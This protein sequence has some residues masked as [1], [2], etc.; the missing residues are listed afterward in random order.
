MTNAVSWVGA[1]FTVVFT[2]GWAY[3]VFADRRSETHV[4][5]AASR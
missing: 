2:L 5:T 4:V 3:F 1:G